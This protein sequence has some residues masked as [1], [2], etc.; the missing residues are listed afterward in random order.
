MLVVVVA[1]FYE[2]ARSQSEQMNGATVLYLYVFFFLK[3]SRRPQ[4][5]QQYGRPIVCSSVRQEGWLANRR[6]GSGSG[7]CV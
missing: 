6:V 7:R 4:Q 5:Q 1:R 2:R 3:R